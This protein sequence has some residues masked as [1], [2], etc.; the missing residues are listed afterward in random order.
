VADAIFEAVTV[1]VDLG[2]VRV[3]VAVPEI[4]QMV[5]SWLVI[6]AVDSLVAHDGI[7]PEKSSDYGPAF[8]GNLEYGATVTG[9]AYARAR[10]V[11]ARI[12]AVYDEMFGACDVLV[13][14]ATADVAGA[15]AD[16]TNEADLTLASVGF[17]MPGNFNGRP[18]L[19]MPCGFSAD[20]MPIAL[21]IVGNLR[22]EISICR[23]GRAY[24]SA[25]GW[26]ERRPDI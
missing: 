7:Y 24:E 4:D 14:P 25:T 8:L 22:D 13:T 10:M 18:S 20:D 2:A 3:D 21:Q 12:S 1:L 9:T 23:L 15:V 17:A 19:T 16:R 6:C 5:E 26:H 11:Q